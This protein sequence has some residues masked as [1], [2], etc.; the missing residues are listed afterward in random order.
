MMC[1]TTKEEGSGCC[2]PKNNC[3]CTHGNRR[4]ISKEEKIEMLQE[5]KKQLENE[6]RGVEERLVELKG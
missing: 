3:G 2:A 1:E 6:I 5:Y 4:F